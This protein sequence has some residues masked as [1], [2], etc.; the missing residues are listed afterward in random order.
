M[1]LLIVVAIIGVLISIA[2]ASYTT[3][4]KKSRDSRRMNDMKAI[5]NAWEQYYADNSAAYPG[6]VYPL[7]PAACT[8]TLITTPA[9]YLP[10]GF[11]KDPKGGL[12]YP[13]LDG[14][15]RCGS[16]TYCFCAGMEGAISAN[17]V[18]DCSGVAT[19]GYNG[20][21]CVNNLQ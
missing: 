15:S 8:L 11:P 14:W 2:V 13:E 6:P 4:Q 21:Y 5:Q 19:S 12:P 16:A 10:A 1:E 20:F 3:A 18:V 17:A 9:I 7:P